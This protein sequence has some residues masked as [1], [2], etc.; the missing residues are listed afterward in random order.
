MDVFIGGITAVYR[1]DNFVVRLFDKT[2]H[3][4]YA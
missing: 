1:L 4:R 3:V 2:S